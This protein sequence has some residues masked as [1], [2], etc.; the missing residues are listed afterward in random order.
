MNQASLFPTIVGLCIALVGT[1]LPVGR[2][3]SSPDGFVAR[4]LEQGFLWTLFGLVLAIVILWEKQ[5]LSSIGF[6][7]QWQSVAWGLLLMAVVI[8]V[9]GPLGDWALIQS[10]LPG[11]ESGFTKLAN[12]PVWFLAVA[13]VT[14]GIVEETLY[15]GYAI[16]RLALLTGNYWW[17]GLLAWA[18]F[19]LVHTPFWGW[20]PVLSMSIAG[21]P[22]LVYY[23]LKHD[24]LACIIAHAVTDIVGLI[25]L[26]HV[27][28]P[29]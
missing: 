17:A 24:L 16:E 8:L 14:A 25:I 6:R 11:F 2:L 3:L 7:W 27:A 19:G 26:P 23:I 22:I 20:G 1:A 9:T 28:R 13:A 10:G 29:S 5:S 21:I 18:A 15:R 4:V 12:L